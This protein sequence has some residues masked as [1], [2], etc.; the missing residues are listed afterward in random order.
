[1][2]TKFLI[3]ATLWLLAINANQ[4]SGDEPP[5][6]LL[7]PL[8]T[9]AKSTNQVAAPV[10]SFKLKPTAIAPAAASGAAEAKSGMLFIHLTHLA[11]GRYQVKAER[12]DGAFKHLG[13]ISITDPTLAPDHETNNNKKEASA[14]PQADS[15]ET[16]V[17]VKLPP[18]VTARD[19]A[20]IL[21]TGPGGNAFLSSDA[22]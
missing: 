5:R 9:D 21:L 22:K 1:V 15:L 12:P 3:V 7:T 16:E 11:P 13:S 6:P 2:K 4:S 17:Q 18:D 14:G 20:R 10:L 19:I 8:P